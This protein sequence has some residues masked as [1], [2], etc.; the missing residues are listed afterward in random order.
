VM[1][2][3]RGGRKRV[4]KPFRWVLRPIT[5]LI[6]LRIAYLSVLCAVLL[7]IRHYT[8]RE[9]GACAASASLIWASLAIRFTLTVIAVN[10]SWILYLPRPR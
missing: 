3:G 4:A 7:P 5:D 10:A 2:G 8:A 6:S 9:V 1:E